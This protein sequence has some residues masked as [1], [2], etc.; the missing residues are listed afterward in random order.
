MRC[1]GVNFLSKYSNINE[2]ETVLMM[3]EY[4]TNAPHSSPKLMGTERTRIILVKLLENILNKK[5]IERGS[6]TITKV[7]TIATLV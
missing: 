7:K 3:S 6:E 2:T 4:L 1:V 5:T